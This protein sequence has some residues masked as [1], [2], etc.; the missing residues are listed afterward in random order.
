MTR[1]VAAASVLLALAGWQQPVSQQAPPP[2]PTAIIAGRVAD[3]AGAPIVNAVVWSL[4]FGQ[5]APAPGRGSQ[6]DRVVTNAEGRFAFLGLAAGSYRIEVSKPGWLT[7]AYGRRRPGG[8]S[9]PLNLKDGERRNDLALTMW[10]VGVLGG[11]VTA[12]NGDPLIGV[13]VRAMR[14]FYSAGIPRY[15]TPIRARTDDRGEYRFS[16]LQ[17]GDY[18]VVVL[19]SVLSEPPTFAGAIRAGGETPRAYLQTMTGIATA[20]M[21]FDR[22]T[23]VMGADQP[24]TSSLSQ[25]LTAPIDGKPL[26]AYATTFHP[27]STSMATAKSVRV[28]AGEPQE[29]VDVVVRMAPTWQVSGTL[30]DADGPLQW[31]AVHLVPADGGDVPVVDT[32]TAVT[33]AKGAFTFFGVPPGQYIAR[34]VRSPWPGGGGFGITGGT[35][36]IP[37][38]SMM[39]GPGAP[40]TEP[41]MH[42]SENVAVG[43]RHVRGLTLVMQ[44]GARM[45]GLVRFE[46]KAEEPTDLSRV[47]VFLQ[48]ANRGMD[49]NVMPGT[50]TNDRRFATAS[51]LPGRYLL[52]VN[53]PGWVLKSAMYQGR[54][55][56][57]TVFDLSAD[58]DGAVLTFT[59]QP[60]S[61]RGNVTSAVAA[62]L[63]GAQVV[64]FAADS[65]AWVDNGRSIPYTSSTPVGSSGE[66][67]LLLPPDGEYFVVPLADEDSDDWQNPATL[68]RLSAM[69][70]RIRVQGESIT[71]Q[72]LQLR[73]LR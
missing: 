53:P 72:S 40:L 46:G 24:L 73:R 19:M 41:L 9:I 64:V 31:H 28:V 55:I 50:M 69:A 34:S 21:L 17:P 25:S 2:P 18:L 30:R 39:S 49:R 22:A 62:D 35:G 47:F 38:I 57:N 63:V 52:R 60:P 61:I 59:D 45:T 20:P 11:R 3:A 7:G 5:A 71:G 44:P 8:G 16:T 51:V 4:A 58:I 43:N 48:P 23:G 56:A 32:A 27:S 26:L 42:V 68:K 15:V 54:D 65:S 70:V 29:N 6:G 37:Q 33:D 12:D 67:S 13:E 14:R 1:L 36:A 10:R 66:F